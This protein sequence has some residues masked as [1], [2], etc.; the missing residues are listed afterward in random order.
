M[1]ASS[2][3]L[4]D[5]PGDHYGVHVE[6][7][8]DAR[9]LHYL[10]G[11][12]GA[13]KVAGSAARYAEKYPGSKIFVSVLLKRYGIKVPPQVYTE[14]NT[15]VYRVYILLHSS[16]AKLKVGVSGNWIVRSGQFSSDGTLDAF[17]LDRSIGV[18]FGSDKKGALAAETL[19]KRTFDHCRTTPPETVPYG[20]F[21][22]KEWFFDGVY[23]EML[24]SVKK[25][26]SPRKRSVLSLRTALLY[27]LAV[28]A[29]LDGSKHEN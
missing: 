6:N 15:P 13:A 11:R 16:S 5:L 19:V 3:F 20:A 7:E 21:G 25:F 22:H 8:M 10:V 27:D 23:S 9:R 2:Q 18:Y 28:D 14:V 17:D 4:P 1:S 26:D 12:I 29:V 24:D